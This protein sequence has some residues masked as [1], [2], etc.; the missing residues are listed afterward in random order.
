M[1]NIK[2]IVITSKGDP[3]VGLFDQEWEIS[4]FGNI[5]LDLSIYAEEDQEQIKQKLSEDLSQLFQCYF[6]GDPCS[7]EFVEE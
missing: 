6:A 4:S 1:K 5:A 7:V 2:R 3:S